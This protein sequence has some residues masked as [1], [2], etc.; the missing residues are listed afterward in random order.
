MLYWR[1]LL[2]GFLIFG[3]PGLCMGQDLKAGVPV[4]KQNGNGCL[5]LL[6]EDAI[7]KELKLDLP[8]KQELD[9]KI[10]LLVKTNSEFANLI[11]GGIK[12]TKKFSELATKSRE[13]LEEFDESLSEILDPEQASRLVAICVERDGAIALS[14]ILVA[15]HLKLTFAQRQKIARVK[16]RPSGL[17]I[18]G[19]SPRDALEKFKAQN[20]QRGEEYLAVL[21]DQQ[22][23]VFDGL[24]TKS[25]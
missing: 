20:E 11:L 10:E 16:M 5:A 9:T 21:T 17:L 1:C 7:R 14:Y 18:M 22:R 2:A 13:M 15:D 12:D 4:I 25:K 6:Q 23:T 19:G 3:F 24:K 8:Q